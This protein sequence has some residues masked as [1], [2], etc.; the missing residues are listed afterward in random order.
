M[1]TNLRESYELLGLPTNATE[2]EVRK[3]YKQKARECHPDKNPDDPQATEK[4]QALRQGY[5]RIVSGSSEEPDNMEYFSGFDSF[6][7]FV[8]FREMMRR[9][10]R[11][12]MMARMFGGLFDDDSD[13]DED[14]FPY[15]AFGRP[16]FHRS[17]HHESSARSQNFRSREQGNSRYGT[18]SYERGSS[19]KTPPKEPRRDRKK[20]PSYPDRSGNSS[21]PKQT[22]SQGNNSSKQNTTFHSDRE[23]TTKSKYGQEDCNAERETYREERGKPTGFAKSK[24]KSKTRSQMTASEWQKGRKSKKN[25]KKKQTAKS[26]SSSPFKT[27]TREEISDSDIESE[28]SVKRGQP[29]PQQTA[30][31]RK[32][33]DEHTCSSS[34]N[35]EEWSL[36]DTKKSEADF[37]GDRTKSRHNSDQGNHFDRAFSFTEFEDTGEKEKENVSSNETTTE[38]L[39]GDKNSAETGDKPIKHAD[40]C[41]EE[42]GLRNVEKDGKFPQEGENFMFDEE[43]EFTKTRQSNLSKDEFPKK[44]AKTNTV[45]EE[46]DSK[47]NLNIKTSKRNENEVEDNYKA[48]QEVIHLNTKGTHAGQQTDKAPPLTQISTEIKQETVEENPSG[49]QDNPNRT[50][51]TASATINNKTFIPPTPG[52]NRV[53]KDEKDNVKPAIV[54]TTK[55]QKPCYTQSKQERREG[56]DRANRRKEDESYNKNDEWKM[57]RS[58]KKINAGIRQTVN[59]ENHADRPEQSIPQKKEANH[60]G[61]VCQDGVNSSKLHKPAGHFSGNK[62]GKNKYDGKSKSQSDGYPKLGGKSCL[63]EL[64]FDSKE[65]QKLTGNTSNRRNR[66]EK[67]QE[68][69][70]QETTESQESSVNSSKTSCNDTTENDNLAS[71]CS[72]NVTPKQEFVF[73][74]AEPTIAYRKA[75]LDDEL[76]QR[77][78]SKHEKRQE[79]RQRRV[80]DLLSG[81]M[82]NTNP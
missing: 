26:S 11:E 58:S 46:E 62:T 42:D 81:N 72:S 55:V 73:E 22:Q 28:T 82:W 12:E 8:I 32:E 9:R 39:E 63:H 19:A 15:G 5:E 70:A 36:G 23:E 38:S 77:R 71:G 80:N 57:A 1:A 49:R 64:Q 18:S 3:A 7:H 17:R 47:I 34:P 31:N 13:L 66:S 40:N 68:L 35:S 6:F 25:H 2:E 52:V 69:K 16:F 20:K 37:N 54:K 60:H 61:E 65:T 75:P 24:Q 53:Q 29:F 51:S 48:E 27:K 43:V 67:N 50:A 74:R 78:P 56:D 30:R 4:F 41:N 10:M 33:Q 44:D 79:R 21:R 59:A 14:D 45:L 76:K